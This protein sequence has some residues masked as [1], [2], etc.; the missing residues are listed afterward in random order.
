MPLFTRINLL[1]LKTTA[2]VTKHLRNAARSVASSTVENDRSTI[3]PTA[4]EK[5]LICVASIKLFLHCSTKAIHVG[6]LI[7]QCLVLRSMPPASRT[8]K[9]ELPH[10]FT[11]TRASENT[12]EFFPPKGLFPA[13]DNK[14]LIA[15]CSEKIRTNTSLA[16]PGPKSSGKRVVI[17]IRNG[18]SIKRFL[19]ICPLSLGLLLQLNMNQH[20]SSAR[21][22]SS[23]HN[24]TFLWHI[25]FDRSSLI[26]SSSPDW[27]RRLD[28]PK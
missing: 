16:T 3:R 26:P 22:T 9:G 13:D 7:V 11:T 14:S 8:A 19:A 21:Q 28:R 25:I 12:F 1:L 10:P 27:K 20:A 23:M 4:L 5:D 2:N 17:K 18:L 6:L 24:R 15:S